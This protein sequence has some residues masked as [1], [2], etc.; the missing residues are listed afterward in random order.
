MSDERLTEH[1]Q[2]MIELRGLEGM[3]DMTSERFYELWTEGKLRDTHAFNRWAILYEAANAIAPTPAPDADEQEA[4]KAMNWPQSAF[5]DY[6]ARIAALETQ[7]RDLTRRL[8][9]K[10]GEL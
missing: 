8:D 9:A 2:I 5:E 7:V 3:Y 1:Q 6:E 10:D 4:E